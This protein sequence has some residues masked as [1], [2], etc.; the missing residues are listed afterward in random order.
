MTDIEVAPYTGAWI[1]ITFIGGTWE[2]FGVAPYTGAWI[3]ISIQCWFPQECRQSHPTRVRGLKYDNDTTITFDLVAP[4][5]G[6][7]IEIEIYQSKIGV[8]ESHPTRVRGLKWGKS[9]SKGSGCNCRTLH[10]CVD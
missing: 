5:T 7:W 2:R 3:E 6:A 4:Y 1:E 9:C 8:I 10:G